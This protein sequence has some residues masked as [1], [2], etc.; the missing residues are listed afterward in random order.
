MDKLRKLNSQLDSSIRNLLIK[1]KITEDVEFPAK[2][3]RYSIYS[4]SSLTILTNFG[5]NLTPILASAGIGGVTAGFALKDIAHNYMCGALLQVQKPFTVGKTV[6]FL[7]S[8]PSP[9]K[10]VVKSITARHVI[11]ENKD[12]RIMIPASQ[13]YSNSF[14]IFSKDEK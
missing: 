12:G 2:I 7:K 11:I 6:H 14:I 9:L 4:L 8:S 10:G 1:A 5:I 3:M 13:A